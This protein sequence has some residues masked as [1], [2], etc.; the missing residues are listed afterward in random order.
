MVVINHGKRLCGIA[1]HDISEILNLNSDEIEPLPA[2]NT[3]ED[4]EFY[5]GI[6]RMGEQIV[7]LLDLGS[8]LDFAQIPTRLECS[9]NATTQASATIDR[10]SIVKLGDIRIGIDIRQIDRIT[11]VPEIQPLDKA[12]AGVKGIA[13]REGTDACKAEEKDYYK[14][15]DLFK[16]MNLSE[17]SGKKSLI[18]SEVSGVS[19]GFYG[20]QVDTIID[21]PEDA[22]IAM[23]SLVRTLDNRYI[24]SVIKT[25]N[26][27]VLFVDLEEILHSYGLIG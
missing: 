12:P 8:I 27:L 6:K 10:V 14:I 24:K 5:I 1:L 17:D 21:I 3:Q 23:P 11:R 13:L 9:R 22:L 2:V 16:V 7:T 4:D 26:D 18:L 25:S 20:G 19:T 15:V